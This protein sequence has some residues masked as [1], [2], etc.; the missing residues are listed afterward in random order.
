MIVGIIGVGVV[1]GAI[2][3][4]FEKIGHTVLTHDIRFENSSI[5]RVLDSEICYIS[6]TT[7]PKQDGS[8]NIS[9]FEEVIESL[10]SQKYSGIIAIKSTVEPGTTERLIQKYRNLNI[11]F[12]PEF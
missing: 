12:V 2:K 6:V 7:P 11:C 4:G 1:G 10:S 3:H 9:I 8:C 5:D